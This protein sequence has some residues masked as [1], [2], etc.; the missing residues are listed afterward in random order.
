MT[1]AEKYEAAGDELWNQFVE[2]ASKLAEKMFQ[3]VVKPFCD[4]H[5]VYFDTGMGAYSFSNKDHYIG[6]CND[7]EHEYGVFTEEAPE[8]YPEVWFALHAQCG[9][10]DCLFEFLGNF[11]YAP[12]KRQ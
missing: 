7:W 12:R 5:Q 2:E 4:K 10:N 3:E 11:H 8:D 1:P 9:P 6:L